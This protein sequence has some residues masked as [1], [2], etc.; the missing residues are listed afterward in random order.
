[1]DPRLDDRF[2]TAEQWRDEAIALRRIL[3][4]CGLTEERKWGKPCYSCE[5]GN[6]AIIQ[7]MKSF[8][9]LMFFKGVLLDDPEGLL[10]SQGRHTRSAL[11]M[12]F[13]SVE[14]VERAEGLRDV[15]LGPEEPSLLPFST[16]AHAGVLRIED[17]PGR[18]LSRSEAYPFR[19][20]VEAGFTSIA[21]M[22]FAETGGE[23]VL[24][25]SLP[26]EGGTFEGDLNLGSLAPGRYG[27]AMVATAG[28]VP[29]SEIAIWLT[30]MD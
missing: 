5:E 27:W 19:G 6:V 25:M 15:L 11:R 3:L 23:V 2:Q 17:L 28:E 30:I 26:A 13:T 20:K 10:H 21:L 4:D 7:R 9:A 1:M 16:F 24:G 22:I 12:Q 14:E 29:A 18:L 8:L